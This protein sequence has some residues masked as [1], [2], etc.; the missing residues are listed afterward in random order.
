MNPLRTDRESLARRLAADG[1][2][3]ENA[4]HG[5]YLRL[6]GSHVPLEVGAFVDGWF[7]VQDPASMVAVEALQPA[8]GQRILDL[9]AAP[10]AKTTAIAEHL[11]NRGEV[12]AFDSDPERLSRVDQNRRRLGLTCITMLNDLAQAP[13]ASF[14][15][16]LVD[17]PCSNT[18]V[19]ARRVEARWRWTTAQLH[20]LM[21]VQRTLVERAMTL[22][23]PGGV[24][25]YSTC[26]L[27]PEE[28]RMALAP[29]T[30]GGQLELEQLLL[31]APPHHDGGY[32]ARWRRPE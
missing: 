29:L 2:A 22:V 27:E 4:P 8:P 25:V 9:C 15:A 20:N 5:A 31:P 16:V 6:V 10:G 7:S 12:V 19:L 14:D 17:A 24:L 13:P 28:N 1:V 3:T 32:V 21:V 30:T 23:R 26:S 11:G 18:G